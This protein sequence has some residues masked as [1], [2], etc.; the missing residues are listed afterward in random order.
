M[1]RISISLSLSFS[2]HS[3]FSRTAVILAPIFSPV[4]FC[5]VVESIYRGYPRPPGPVFSSFFRQ[6]RFARKWG[7][8][9]RGA[10]GPYQPLLLDCGKPQPGYERGDL[11]KTKTERTEE[12]N[13]SAFVWI[14][15]ERTTLPKEFLLSRYLWPL[16]WSHGATDLWRPLSSYFAT[17]SMFVLYVAWTILWTSWL[18]AS[19]T[20]LDQL[21]LG[22]YK[23]IIIFCCT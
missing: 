11:I 5:D 16:L 22:L 19:L 6:A 21:C 13:W 3:P 18:V 20:C 14:A 17:S 15:G 2:S 8:A 23:L 9:T 4:L 10:R 12:N 7:A 1:R